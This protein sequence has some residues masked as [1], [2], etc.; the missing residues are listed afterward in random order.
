MKKIIILLFAAILIMAFTQEK[1]KRVDVNVDKYDF[2][3]TCFVI[4]GDQTEL[5]K[6][7]ERLFPSHRFFLESEKIRFKDKLPNGDYILTIACFKIVKKDTVIVEYE[8]QSFDKAGFV[9]TVDESCAMKY[10]YRRTDNPKPDN[11]KPTKQI[12]L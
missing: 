4:K 11:S 6:E 7:S 1:P 5:K 10:G 8:L 3:E 12:L 9:V 2:V